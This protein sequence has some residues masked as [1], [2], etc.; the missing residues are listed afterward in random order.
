MQIDAAVLRDAAGP[1]TIER[2]EL[3]APGPHEVL[4]RIVGAGMCHTDVLPRVGGLSSPPIVNGHEGAGVVQLVGSSVNEVSVGDHVVLS[5]DSCGRCTNCLAHSPAYCDRL[6]EQYPMSRIN[7]A[8][9]SSLAGGTIKPV[10]IPG[11]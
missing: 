5:F 2:V 6:I 8:E 10:L 9:Q 11:S 1:Y 7:E 3:A 4:V